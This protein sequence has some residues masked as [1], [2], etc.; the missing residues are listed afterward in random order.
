M[1]S[2][3]SFK[4]A[5]LIPDKY[6][7][8]IGEVARIAG[9]KPFV[10][11]YWETEFP[12][13]APSKTKSQQRLYSRKEVERVL[14]IRDLLYREK[15][16]IEG[17]RKRLKEVFKAEK[18]TKSLEQM[19]LFPTELSPTLSFHQELKNE[20]NELLA[21]VEVYKTQVSV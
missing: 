18:K 2:D 3:E 12:E 14:K 15:F 8:K 9:V 5:S 20:L 17:A 4:E 1:T 6:Y 10:L 13:I 16:T 19:K 7:F 21:L 11:R